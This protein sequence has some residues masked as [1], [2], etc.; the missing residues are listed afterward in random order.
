MVKPKIL[1]K[2]IILKSKELGNPDLSVEA[3]FGNLVAVKF[4]IKNKEEVN[5][6]FWYL[7]DELLSIYDIKKDKGN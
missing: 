1:K 7:E 4:I 2:G 3:I 5:P 6:L